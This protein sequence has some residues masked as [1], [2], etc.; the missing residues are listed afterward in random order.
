MDLSKSPAELERRPAIASMIRCES[1]S[2]AYIGEQS[3]ALIDVHA[4]LS[5][6]LTVLA[7]DNA[8]GKTTLGL[9]C[10]AAIPHWLVGEPGKCHGVCTIDGRPTER[11]DFGRITH[12]L[13]QGAA[14]AF[15]GE[16]VD[17]E[18]FLNGAPPLSAAA[19][20]ALNRALPARTPLSRMSRGEKAL[21]AAVLAISYDRRV[22]F[23]DE[24][25]DSLDEVNEEILGSFL[26]CSRK[27]GY[28]VLLSRQMYLETP[29]TPDATLFARG[30]CISTTKPDAPAASAD[31]TAEPLPPGRPL[32]HAR[33]IGVAYNGRPILNDASLEL[34]EHEIIGLTGRNGAGKSTLLR[35]LAGLQRPDAGTVTVHDAKTLRQATRLCSGDPDAE[36]FESTVAR[37][38]EAEPRLRDRIRS[39]ARRSEAVA[40][41]LR[42]LPFNGGDDPAKLSFGQRKLLSLACAIAGAPDVLL[43]DE[44]T[45]GLDAAARESVRRWLDAFVHEGGRAVVMATQSDSAICMLYHRRVHLTGGRVA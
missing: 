17:A 31:E 23:L 14:E 32:L 34:R 43:L 26:A 20:A 22:T 28:A 10:A 29:F 37:E 8:S 13:F 21:A 4:T 40:A 6:G 42:D 18:L 27:T 5:A 3:P 16:T 24:I 12:V 15:V 2:F 1:F 7:G 25:L 35:I 11:S 41:V 36:L 30:G 39:A 45:A 38:I 33:K 44:P 19:S 9:V